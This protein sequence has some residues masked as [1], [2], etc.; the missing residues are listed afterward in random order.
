MLEIIAD[1]PGYIWSFPRPDHLAIGVCGQADAGIGAA[2][3]RATTAEWIATTGIAR[4]ARLEP[5]SWP[6]PS[7]SADDFAHLTV[8]GPR[9]MLAATAAGLVDP[10]TREGIYFALAS[11]QWA[12]DSLLAGSDTVPRAGFHEDEDGSGS[13]HAPRGSRP[14]SS[15]RLSHAC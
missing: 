2:A 14:D 11:G 4:G 13:W 5:Y 6:I 10:I 3:L 1:P 9:W 12:A 15:D 8:A 7:L